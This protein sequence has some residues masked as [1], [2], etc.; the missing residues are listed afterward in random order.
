L[1]RVKRNAF[2]TAP[3]ERH[4]VILMKK[5]SLRSRANSTTPI[6]VRHQFDHEVPTVIHH[7]E[8]K[9]TALARLTHR[10]IL[11]PGKYA[12][13]A[14]GI[15]AV[16]L[17]IVVVS[18]WTSSSRSK[19]SEVWTKL[20]SAAKPEDLTETAKEFPGIEPTQ[21]A[22]LRAANEYYNTAMAD[23]PNNREVAVSNLRRALDLYDQVATQSPKDSFRARAALFGKARCLEARNELAKAIEQYELVA[24]NWPDSAE[25]DTAKKLV[26]MLKKPDAASFY[27]ELYAYSPPRVTLPP[28]GNEKIDFPGRPGAATPAKG[29]GA[30][31][32]TNRILGPVEVTPPDLSE[33][34]SAPSGA[35]PGNVFTPEKKAEPKTPR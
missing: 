2:R 5:Q 3:L 6:P 24:S 14:L 1:T 22:L 33:I 12:T 25:A 20:D 26:E 32:P 27:K 21:W 17:A 16:V 8:E 4:G 13:W 28:L 30:S 10:V 34:Q 11:D 29:T 7:P 18:N 23:L 15:L 35:L 9:M 31:S 19:N